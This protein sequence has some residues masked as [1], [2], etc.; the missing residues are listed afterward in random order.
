MHLRDRPGGI[1]LIILIDGMT[2]IVNKV[3]L[4]FAV[5]VDKKKTHKGP[6]SNHKMQISIIAQR[7]PQRPGV[8]AAENFNCP[9]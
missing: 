5:V 4:P 8:F 9:G 7:C 3:C 2:G 6:F 1:Q